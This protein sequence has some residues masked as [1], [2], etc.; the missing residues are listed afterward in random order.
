MK[1]ALIFLLV[2]VTFCG[3]CAFVDSENRRVFNWYSETLVPKKHPARALS[4]PLIIP[5]GLA[6]LL[7]DIVIVHPICSVDDA[8][9][10]TRDC[11]WDSDSFNWDDE[12][13]T[14]CTLLVPRTVATPI[15]AVGDWALRCVFPISPNKSDDDSKGEHKIVD[16]KLK[17]TAPPKPKL[18][19]DDRGSVLVTH[20][21]YA[22]SEQDPIFVRILTAGDKTVCYKIDTESRKKSQKKFIKTLCLN[23]QQYSSKKAFDM[24]TA[25][26]PLLWM[27]ACDSRNSLV[28]WLDQAGFSVGYDRERRF[29]NPALAK[30]LRKFFETKG[31]LGPDSDGLLEEALKN[32][33]S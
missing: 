24:K 32:A 23:V 4:Y 7:T 8:L 29:V 12:Y 11:C 22:N 18:I 21:W 26:K 5:V 10:D 30:L 31:L 3:G 2:G 1:S 9:R 19:E 13:V 16:E 17:E 27:V 25:G 15:V 28:V 14:E 20:F 33:G 6:A